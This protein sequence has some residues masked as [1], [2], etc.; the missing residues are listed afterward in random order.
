MLL[1]TFALIGTCL[2]EVIPTVEGAN[3]ATE[4]VQ[5]SR[6]KTTSIGFNLRMKQFSFKDRNYFYL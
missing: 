2:G 5:N 6:L 1:Q 3:M 4:I